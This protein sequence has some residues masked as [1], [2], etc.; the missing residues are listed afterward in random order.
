MKMPT[1]KSR[2]P[3][4]RPRRSPISACKSRG[5]RRSFSRARSKLLRPSAGC[6]R[7]SIR[8]SS[9]AA[10][11]SISTAR[12]R[13]S[14]TRCVSGTRAARR[15]ISSAP[16]YR[17]RSI[18]CTP[19]ELR[20]DRADAAAS[21]WT[22][23]RSKPDFEFQAFDCAFSAIVRSLERLPNAS[24]CAPSKKASRSRLRTCASA[25]TSF[26]RSTESDN[27]SGCGPKRFSERLKIISICATPAAIGCSSRSRRC[28][29]SQSTRRPKVRRRVFQKWAARIGRAPRH[30][31]PRRS[32]RSP[33]SWLR[34]TP[35]ARC[36]MV[37]LSV[38]I[39]RG[40]P[41]WRR[42][43]RTSRRPTSRRLSAQPNPTWSRLGRWTA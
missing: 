12:S 13:S 41:K 8:T 14:P 29:R 40:K 38:R 18:S 21:L 16:P 2:K 43:S 39:R 30:A 10:R 11:S 24:K 32:K 27:I 33:I 7:R 9:S 23:A 5:T 37:S 36:R 31:F 3:V 1:G 20:S 35:S 22:T 42:P 17:G 34:S 6:R 4:P 15:S 25:T 19:R 28:I 26:T